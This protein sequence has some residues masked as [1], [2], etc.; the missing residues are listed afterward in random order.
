MLVLRGRGKGGGRLGPEDL[1]D[2]QGSPDSCDRG[3]AAQRPAR[4]CRT[5]EGSKEA[6]ELGLRCWRRVSHDSPH[7]L[8]SIKESVSSLVAGATATQ[9][10]VATRELLETHD[11]GAGPSEHPVGHLRYM[12]RCRREAVQLM[13]SAVALE[14]VVARSVAGLSQA[15]RASTQM[16]PRLFPARGSRRRRSWSAAVAKNTFENALAWSPSDRI[17]ARRR[18]CRLDIVSTCV[19]STPA[20]PGIPRGHAR[21][22]GPK[23]FQRLGGTV[24]NAPASGLG[25]AARVVVER[26]V[27]RSA[28]DDHARRRHD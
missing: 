20:V 21:Q 16:C 22:G 25:P 8:S 14:E 24:P 12:S 3:A 6:N 9:A 4:G 26:R 13:V 7:A 10:T 17:R 15:A 28:V 11:D 19:S 23:P 5:V 27:V 18:V 1:E 2:L